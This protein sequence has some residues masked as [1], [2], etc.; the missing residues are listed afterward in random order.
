MAKVMEHA[1]G[2][3]H[4]EEQCLGGR[5]EKGKGDRGSMAQE[6]GGGVTESRWADGRQKLGASRWLSALEWQ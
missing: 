6:V 1:D 2:Q 3:E 5:R 4:W